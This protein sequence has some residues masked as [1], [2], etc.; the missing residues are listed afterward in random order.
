MA[1]W[2]V[3]SRQRME[4]ESLE[5]VAEVNVAVD[6]QDVIGALTPAHDRIDALTG[7]PLNTDQGPASSDLLK[8]VKESAGQ[9]PV[10]GNFFFALRALH[11]VAWRFFGIHGLAFMIFFCIHGLAFMIFFCIHG[12]AFMFFL[13]SRLDIHVFLVGQWSSFFLCQVLLPKQQRRRKLPREKP[14]P[15]PKLLLEQVWPWNLKAKTWLRRRLPYA[16]PLAISIWFLLG[17]FFFRP[18]CRNQEGNF[19]C[20]SP[21]VG[22]PRGWKFWR[23]QPWDAE[24]CDRTDWQVERNDQ[25]FQQAWC[26]KIGLTT[27]CFVSRFLVASVLKQNDEGQFETYL[28]EITV[29]AGDFDDI[30]W[31]GYLKFLLARW[32]TPG[33]WRLKWK[34]S[35]VSSKSF[36][37]MFY[38]WLVWVDL[39]FCIFAR[40]F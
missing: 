9:I 3:T 23:T 14:K 35:W 21:F 2:V 1:Y 22:P 20:A 36:T 28:A 25:V 26:W 30:S 18:R 33:C 11:F 39:D 15:N 6:A 13:H 32:W 8:F 10:P 31:F 17:Y 40:G 37:A 16:W 38:Q 12:L 29:E 19:C 24:V 4:V 27:T 34:R 7:L 5:R